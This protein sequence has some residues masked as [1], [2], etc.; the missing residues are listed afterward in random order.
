[1][2][3]DQSAERRVILE[4][5]L[6]ENGYMHVFSTCGL[7]DLY[8]VVTTVR[9][10]V[11]LIE[12]DSPSRDTL[13]QL[14][15]I[16]DAR[17]TPVV[18]FAQDQNVQTVHSAVGS[19]VCAYLCERADR[20]SVKPAIALAMATFDAYRS[21]RREADRYRWELDSR[22]KVDRAKAIL[23]RTHKIEEDEAHRLLR[24][25]AMDQNRKLS[26]IVEDVIR[27]S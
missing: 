1:M 12:L 9:P 15:A 7:D 4:K 22:K 13:E 11:V 16:R 20:S 19:G 18:M 23:M 24:K 14:Q 27:S 10:D 21:V 8:D 6:R 26:L 2:L 5:I 3:V 25:M 17:P